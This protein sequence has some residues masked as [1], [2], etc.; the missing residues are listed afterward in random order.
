MIETPRHSIDPAR[1]SWQSHPHNAKE[2]MIVVFQGI[3][4]SICSAASTQIPKRAKAR[5]I[6]WLDRNAGEL[7]HLLTVNPFFSEP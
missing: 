5:M 2:W 3:L 7:F 4:P 6:A 1:H